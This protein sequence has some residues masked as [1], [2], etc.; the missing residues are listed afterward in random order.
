MSL[1]FLF[2]EY[3]KNGDISH[4]IIKVTH[5]LSLW[6]LLLYPQGLEILKLTEAFK[7]PN[8][9]KVKWYQEDY[10]WMNKSWNW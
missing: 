6:P 4:P 9:Y 10:G 1:G 2:G 5:G 7:Y 8:A 3:E